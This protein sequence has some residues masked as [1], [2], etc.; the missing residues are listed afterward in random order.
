MY[1][2]LNQYKP[3]F[4]AKVFLNGEILDAKNAHISVFDRGFI[5][6]DGIYEVIAR[7][8]GKFFYKE[9]HF[10]RLQWCLDEI[11]IPFNARSLESIIP[12]LLEAS[13][14]DHEDCML[15]I[16]LSRGV[17]PRQHSFPKAIIPTVMMYAWPFYFPEINTSH[18]S[19]VTQ[20]DYRWSRCDIK[21][22][23]L[24][25]NVMANENANEKDCFETVFVRD[26]MITEASHCNVFFVK[27]GILYTH[28][29]GPYILD[30]ITR[31]VVLEIC[32][33]LQLE[34]RLE[35]VKAVEVSNMDEAFLTGTGSQIL[36][37]KRLDEHDYFD[38]QPGPLTQRI[39]QAFLE[40]KL[41]NGS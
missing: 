18:A 28:P 20:E 6:G 23:S 1:M 22:T 19:V 30:G 39:Q 2:A 27:Y 4:P 7:I 40:L 14:L 5:F 9:A 11:R 34:V 37:I 24:L 3:S 8:N 16:Q 29:A 41:Q 25:G 33:Q 13:K 21:S 10:N 32:E 31:Q 35:A 38:D 12:E 15:Y 26:G 36:A 17:A